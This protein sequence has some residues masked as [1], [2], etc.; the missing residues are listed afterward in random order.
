MS[1]GC[2]LLNTGPDAVYW[3]RAAG[4]SVATWEDIVHG[5]LPGCAASMVSLES[6]LQE[7]GA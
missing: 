5:R 7:A 3:L 1:C 2:R 6:S 4:R